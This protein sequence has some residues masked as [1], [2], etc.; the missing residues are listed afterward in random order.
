MTNDTKEEK[1]VPK[2]KSLRVICYIP[3]SHKIKKRHWKRYQNSG[4]SY[5]Y[6]NIG[7]TGNRFVSLYYGGRGFNTRD[8]IPLYLLKKMVKMAEEI[9]P[10]KCNTNQL[11]R[12]EPTINK[13]NFIWAKKCKEAKFARRKGKNSN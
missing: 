6:F 8:E 7:R 12:F 3:C 9:Q 13:E 10:I 1:G 5:V 4:T 11:K 2:K